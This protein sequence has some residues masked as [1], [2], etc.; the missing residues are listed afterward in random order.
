MIQLRQFELVRV[1]KFLQSPESYNGWRINQRVPQIGDVGTIVEILQ[2]DGS[3]DCFVVESCDSNGMT[4]W[5]GDF[6]AEE[7]EP[8]QE[9]TR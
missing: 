2:G 8:L 6:Q 5:L 4:L 7:L 3:P 1:R 9:L